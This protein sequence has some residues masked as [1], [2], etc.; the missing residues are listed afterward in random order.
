[1][2]NGIGSDHSV[3]SHCFPQQPHRVVVALVSQAVLGVGCSCHGF[4]LDPISHQFQNGSPQLAFVARRDQQPVDTVS[5]QFSRTA[6]PSVHNRST[7]THRLGHDKPVAL[8]YTERIQQYLRLNG[9]TLQGV[10]FA[11]TN[12]A[13][14]FRPDSISYRLSYP[15]AHVLVP[16][17]KQPIL[18]API[19]RG[20]LISNRLRVSAT[21]CQFSCA[22]VCLRSA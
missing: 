14:Y 10:R 18:I 2:T 17:E 21:R 13:Q 1:V 4:S 6:R 16:F 19:V 5:D 3:D 20:G 8:Y 9:G 11:P 7:A 22:S 12:L 15:W